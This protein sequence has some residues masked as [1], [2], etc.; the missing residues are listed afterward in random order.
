MLTFVVNLDME[1][2]KWEQI[3]AQLSA[4]A[5]LRVRRLPAV[6]GSALPDMAA[7]M[8]GGHPQTLQMRGA[9]GCF[10]SHAKIWE[11]LSK[12]DE[13]ICLVLE[14]DAV[15]IGFERLSAIQ[16][17]AD[18]DLVFIN[19][20]MSPASRYSKVKSPIE[21]LDI[22]YALRVLN[23]SKRGVG[24]DGYIITKSGAAKLTAAVT[25]DLYFGHV[26]WRLLRYSTTEEDFASEFANTRVASIVPYHHNPGRPPAW[27]VIKAYCVDSPLVAF[28]VGGASTREEI[29]RGTR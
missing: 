17:P 15:L 8:L 29:D 10:L 7:V 2:S 13:D 1:I 27:G 3:S 23:N 28:A 11:I 24:T 19:D 16:I 18:A 26:D 6:H 5:D 12:A 25:K 20:R 21:F 9:L 14:D 4:F 22:H